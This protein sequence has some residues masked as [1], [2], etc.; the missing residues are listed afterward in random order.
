RT[1]RTLPGGQVETYGYDPAGNL[2]A[3]TNFNGYVTTYTYDALNRLT[4]KLPDPRLLTAGSVP[5]TYAYNA[6]GQRTNMTDVS[7][8][9]ASQYDLRN[10]LI[11]KATPQGALT[12]TYNASGSV[13]SIKSSNQNGTDLTYSYD[14]LNHLERVND[15]P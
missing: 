14:A 3:R 15:S 7:G 10:R 13:A 11:E 12:Y 4:A 5:V 9:T 1:T 8:V 6:L 2:T